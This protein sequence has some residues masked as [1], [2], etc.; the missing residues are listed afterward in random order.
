M[1]RPL[2]ERHRIVV[3]TL[4]VV[5][6]LALVAGL[7]G[8]EPVV[9]DP[10]PVGQA[11]PGSPGRKV[12]WTRSDLWPGRKY[13]TRLR[14]EPRGSLGI[15]TDAG[16]LVRPDV[17]VYWAAGTG[18]EPET[19]PGNARLLGALVKEGVLPFAADLVDQ[20]GRLILYSLADHQPVAFSRPMR[21]T[22]NG[23]LS[24]TP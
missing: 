16:D 6:P 15:E 8:R 2:R 10:S 20:G 5:L 3:C 12:I 9:L 14:G 4:A 11:G 7:R 21:L 1:I 13:V 23:S 24:L 22:S 17:L 19:L 18:R